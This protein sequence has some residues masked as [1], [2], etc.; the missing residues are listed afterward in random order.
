CGPVHFALPSDVA[1][2]EERETE[3]PAAVALTPAG[4]PPPAP[5]AIAR[6]ASEIR[7]ARRPVLVLGLDLDPLATPSAV[8]RFAEA[9]GAPVFVTPKA[10]GVFP[11]DH[12]LFFGVC[13][14]LAADAVIVDF[15]RKADLLIGVGFEPVESDKLWHR[16]MK[17][18]SIGPVSIAS[19]EYRPP[20]E[21]TGDVVAALQA[22]TT[23]KFEPLEWSRDEC[24]AF[25]RE[26]D[27]T[28]RPERE[29][30]QGL[31]PFAVT[32]CLRDLFPPDTIATTDVGSIQL[33]LS[34]SWRP[35]KPPP[36]L[37]S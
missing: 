1:R 27:R 33:I 20:L 9:L 13:G 21:V 15:F 37:P 28:L 24:D 5:G 19:G 12:P 26:L 6:M 7:R 34:H 8:K 11:E 22:L 32:R 23:A 3:D 10:K 29:T 30:T 36:F 31:S 4:P 14:G 17:L 16:T 25:R 18:V 35:T 2:A